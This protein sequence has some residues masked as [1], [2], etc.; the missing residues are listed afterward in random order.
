MTDLDICAE[1]YAR[2]QLNP[3]VSQWRSVAYMAALRAD[4]VLESDPESVDGQ[5]IRAISEK[6]WQ[7]YIDM[8]PTPDVERHNSLAGVVLGWFSKLRKA[9]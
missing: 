8:M 1:A 4:R 2:A 3:T 6:A 7:R 9:A 5:A